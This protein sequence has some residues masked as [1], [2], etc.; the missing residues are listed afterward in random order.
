MELFGDD[1]HKNIDL[2]EILFLKNGLLVNPEDV[3]SLSEGI[4]YLIRN[5][6]KKESIAQM[7]RRFIQENYSIGLIA[8]RYIELYHYILSRR[9]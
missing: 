1:S 3:E 4:L 6:D 7:G 8:D 9:S 2:G 5:R